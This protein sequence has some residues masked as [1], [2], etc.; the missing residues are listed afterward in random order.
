M[1]WSAPRETANRRRQSASL[2]TRLSRGGHR[3]PNSERPRPRPTSAWHG[4]TRLHGAAAAAVGGRWRQRLTRTW[5]RL[6]GGATREAVS[7]PLIQHG[8]SRAPP[9]GEPEPE[10]IQ[11]QPP[12]PTATARDVLPRARGLGHSRPLVRGG[13]QHGVGH[14]M[15]WDTAGHS[16]GW[17]TAYGVSDTALLSSAPRCEAP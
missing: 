3:P 2:A 11:G 1:G 15:G 10:P 17:D 16:T 14:S 5:M 12:P 6:G 8:H 7:P 4:L 13:T 9:R